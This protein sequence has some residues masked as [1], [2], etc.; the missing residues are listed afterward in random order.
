MIEVFQKAEAVIMDITSKSFGDT[1]PVPLRDVMVDSFKR[2]EEKA[3]A[4]E[5]VDNIDST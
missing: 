3:V 1:E 4:P 2:I 5:D